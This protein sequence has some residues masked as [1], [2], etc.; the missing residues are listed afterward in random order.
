LTVIGKLYCFLKGTLQYPPNPFCQVDKADLPLFTAFQDPYKYL[1]TPTYFPFSFLLLFFPSWCTGFKRY[2]EDSSEYAF[3]LV[4]NYTFDY[5]IW[6]SAWMG[7][8][9]TRTSWG[10]LSLR[11]AFP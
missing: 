3:L 2:S 4:E 1:P 11:V 10:N 7:I 9:V 6:A 8:F 5:S